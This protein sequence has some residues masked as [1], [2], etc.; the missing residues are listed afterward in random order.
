MDHVL[1]QCSPLSSPRHRFFGT[2][3]FDAYVFSTFDGG[4]K[5]G[6]FQ[7]ATNHLLRPLPPRPDP[8]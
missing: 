3:A 2:S 4:I 1:F 7:R 6:N 8:P 5:L